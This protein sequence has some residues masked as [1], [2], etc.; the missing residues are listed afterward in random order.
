MDISIITRKYESKFDFT[1]TNRGHEIILCENI[2]LSYNKAISCPYC[3]YTRCVSHL[4]TEAVVHRSSYEVILR[5][6]QK[7]YPLVPLTPDNSS[8]AWQLV[9]GES[10]H[11]AIEIIGTSGNAHFVQVFAEVLSLSTGERAVITSDELFTF[12]MRGGGGPCSGLKDVFEWTRTEKPALI[13]DIQSLEL[14]PAAYKLYITESDSLPD[15]IPR[16]H[17]V[18]LQEVVPTFISLLKEEQIP[19]VSK[20][21]LILGLIGDQRAK[22]ARFVKTQNSAQLRATFLLFKSY[23]FCLR[24]TAS[25]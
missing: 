8:N 9:D 15:F 1:I 16:F 3:R 17:K 7:K 21:I 14:S 18:T 5:K 2:W 12:Q 6:K 10:E 23:S 24:P 19:I 20:A 4:T 22:V 25:V 13:E 11:F